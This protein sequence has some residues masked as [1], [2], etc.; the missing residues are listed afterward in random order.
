MQDYTSFKLA[1]AL[2]DAGFPQP[3]AEFGQVWYTDKGV[4]KVVKKDPIGGHFVSVA[5]QLAKWVYAPSA[6]AIFAEL[7]FWFKIH[8]SAFEEKEIV[9]DG[10]TE[11]CN[12]FEFDKSMAAALARAYINYKTD[13]TNG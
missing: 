5:W 13:P 8:Y 9:C 7:P 12:V 11:H 4:K 3:D 1:V 2:R 10:L 6:A